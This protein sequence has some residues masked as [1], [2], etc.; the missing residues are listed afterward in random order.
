[1][2]TTLRLIGYCHLLRGETTTVE[3]M[4][5]EACHSVDNEQH[6][7]LLQY[8]SV[9]NPL[10]QHVLKHIEENGY[11][12]LPNILS[13]DE[14][15]VEVNRLWNFIEATSPSVLRSDSDT[16]YPSANQNG[17]DGDS[18]T[19][20]DPWP[21]S[22]WLS[23]PDMCQ[24]FQSGWLFSQLREKLAE[25]VFEPLYGTREL[26]SS[27]EGFTFH[28]PTASPP[29]STKTIRHP[30]IGLKPN[31]CNKPSNTNGEHFDQRAAHTGLHCIQSSTALLDQKPDQDGCFLCWP[32]SHREHP[33]ITQ[34]IWR[35]RSDWVP[36]TDEELEGLKERGYAPKR[37]PVNKGDVILWRSDLCHCGVSPAPIS[38]GFRAVSYT[39]MLPA[40]LTADD[41]Y[42][43]K[44]NEYLNGL[45]GDHRPN[46]KMGHLSE[47]KK[48]K[49]HR[50]QKGGEVVNP[51]KSWRGQYFHNGLPNLTRRQKELYGL[52]RYDGAK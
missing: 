21:H 1:M 26:H 11:V 13:E 52:V 30:L 23:L 10:G 46:A 27:K 33:R 18:D 24:S 35:G 28:R 47:P 39:C 43:N 6:D 44:R 7:A 32:G 51:T 37:I 41:M 3:T 15:K 12:V 4:G 40:C 20:D 5:S 48:S 29:G 38:T 22:G 36:L 14:C 34:N 16:W 31:V 50:T 8:I 9:D 2:I 45:S 42:E 25:R 17:T 19:G 49:G